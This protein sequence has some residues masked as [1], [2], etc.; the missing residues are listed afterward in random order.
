MKKTLTILVTI[1]LLSPLVAFSMSFNGVDSFVQG[2]TLQFINNG[3]YSI[4][5]WI[6]P[7]SL[8]GSPVIFSKSLAFSQDQNLH[9]R[10]DTATQMTFGQYSDDLTVT[11]ALATSTWTHLVFTINNNRVEHAYQN[12]RD[13]GNTRTAIAFLNT[14]TAPWAIGKWQNNGQNF[15]G[16]IYDVRVYNRALSATEVRDLYNSNWFNPGLYNGLVAEWLLEGNQSG[17]YIADISGNKNFG[18]STATVVRG[19]SPPM[20][21]YR[22]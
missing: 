8:S 7:D 15:Q 10:I 22:R 1:L 20:G 12:G 5:L 21:R 14:S 6:Y 9:L 3:P 19:A 4:S 17:N 2:N 13:T 18:T 11:V 16:R